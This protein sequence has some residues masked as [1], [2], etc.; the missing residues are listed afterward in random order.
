M[1]EDAEGKGKLRPPP[2]TPTEE[3]WGAAT[4]IQADGWHRHDRGNDGGHAIR[5]GWLRPAGS[6]T[7]PHGIRI[8]ILNL[9]G[10]LKGT[11]LEIGR[12]ADNGGQTRYVFDVAHFLARSDRVAHVDIF[13]RLIDDDALDDAYSVP[14]EVLDD[15][16]AIHRIPFGGRKYRPKEELWP[17]LDDFVAG[18]LRRIREH[19]LIPDWIHSHYADAGYAAAELS[20]LLRIPFAH[21]GHSLGRRKKDKLEAVGLSEEEGER[22]YRFS[23]RI[24]AEETTLRE[25]TFIVTS[26]NDEIETCSDYDH[27]SEAEFRVLPPGV[28]TEKF[29]PYYQARLDP[30][31]ADEE[32]LQR[33][34]WVGEDVERF[35]SQ[36]QKPAILALARPDRHKNLNTLVRIYGEHPEL[37]TLANL[38]IYAGIREDIESMPQGEREVLIELLLSM[39]RYDLYGRMAIPKEHDIEHGVAT[40]YRYCAEKRGV[41]VNAAHH[42]NFGLTIIEAASSGLPVIATKNGGPSEIVPRC[43]NGILVD[44]E[45]DREIR[46]AIVTVL[47]DPEKWR[48]FSDRGILN[49]REIYSWHAHVRQYVEWVEQALRDAGRHPE[50]DPATPTRLRPM[51]RLFVTDIDGTL[52]LEEAGNPGLAEFRGLLAD[53][54]MDVGFG[55]ASGRSF[56]LVVDAIRQFDL[57][58]PDVLICAVGTRISYYNGTE[59]VPDRSWDAHLDRNWDREQIAKLLRSVP[60]LEVQGPEGQNPH[61]I[62]YNLDPERYDERKLPLVLGS[63]WKH[64]TAIR[65]HDAYL[66]ILPRRAS[67]GKALKYLARK[68]ALAP[69]DVVVAGDSGNDRDM[70]TGAHRGVLVGNRSRELDDL[71]DRRDLFRARGHAAAGIIEGLEHFEWL[72]RGNWTETTHDDD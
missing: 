64:V 17:F 43:G 36:P 1:I 59:Y 55:L 72:S 52:V 27:V 31:G 58:P 50:Q 15:H 30:E 38:V 14:V 3:T 40:I 44:P 9:H 35:L 22:R 20:R 7:D 5:P 19:D 46:D 11:G 29:A 4:C 21:T 54:P 61:K 56:E 39:D 2:G 62:S 12:D 47:T 71:G 48:S 63:A 51:Q 57:P 66:D 65:S 33:R 42:E 67:K 49:V 69:K 37:Q 6:M 32:E 25:S 28:D 10:L 23:R 18:A 60:G 45:S 53:R 8:L 13:T 24:A 26:T 34:Y 16:L 41:F 70:L 68:W